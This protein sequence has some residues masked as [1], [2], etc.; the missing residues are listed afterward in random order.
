M[1]KPDWQSKV[2]VDTA[3]TPNVVL[4]LSRFNYLIAII[5]Y[6]LLGPKASRLQNNN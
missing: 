3:R 6:K 4:T 1:P 2:Q 5:F